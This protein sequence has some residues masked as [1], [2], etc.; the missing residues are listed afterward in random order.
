[1]RAPL[2]SPVCG[3]PSL[4]PFPLR[5]DWVLHKSIC[6]TVYS[7]SSISIGHRFW[8]PRAPLSSPPRLEPDSQKDGKNEF[9]IPRSPP[10]F[11]RLVSQQKE[12]PFP[13]GYT[14]IRVPV[15]GLLCMCSGI[16]FPGR[17]SVAS[18][19][20]CS[21]NAGPSPRSRDRRLTFPAPG[22]LN[23][24]TVLSLFLAS[25]RLVLV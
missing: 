17:P 18:S 16:H 23:A 22:R 6:Y 19:L 9:F 24:F 4:P 3:P 14:A 7:L 5:C 15:N 1:V 12:T 21:F 20:L 13:V 25:N 10:P 2:A 8:T 11:L